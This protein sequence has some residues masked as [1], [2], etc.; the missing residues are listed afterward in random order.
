[1]G[2]EVMLH[3]PVLLRKETDMELSAIAT[4]KQQRM[5][6][7]I[8]NKCEITFV[9]KTKQDTWNFINEWLPRANFMSSLDAAIGVQNYRATYTKATNSWEETPDRRDTIAHEIF[10]GEL[11]RGKDPAG[12]LMDYDMRSTAE[13]LSRNDVD[14][15]WD[16]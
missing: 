6:K 2:D 11:L 1:M 14:D 5:I 3:H 8:E 7:Y 13:I 12:A 4:P 15:D 9:G 16:D 10:K